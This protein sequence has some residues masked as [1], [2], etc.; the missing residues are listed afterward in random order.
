[1][2]ASGQL[3]APVAFSREELL[4][5]PF[6]RRVDGP[7]SRFGRFGED[8]FT[9]TLLGFESKIFKAIANSGSYVL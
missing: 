2:Q 4:A 7:Q 9:L 5:Y 3:H 8:K 1:M 6:N